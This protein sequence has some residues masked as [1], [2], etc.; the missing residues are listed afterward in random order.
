MG[1]PPMLLVHV[2]MRDVHVIQC[3]MVV[4]VRVGGQ[5]MTPVLPPVQ[6][7]RHVVVLVPVL[8]RLMLVMTLHPRHSRSHSPSDRRSQDL[9][10]HRVIEPDKPFNGPEE[11]FPD[12]CL[13]FPRF[14]GRCD[15]PPL[16]WSRVV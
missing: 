7:V 15:V 10:V 5:Q 6:V 12:W 11:S 14:R 4:L 9:T 2:P 13:E 3:R 16:R 8:Q 1:F